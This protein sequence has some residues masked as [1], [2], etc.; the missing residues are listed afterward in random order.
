MSHFSLLF[1]R[2][3]R[4]LAFKDDLWQFVCHLE[5]HGLKMASCCTDKRLSLGEFFFL[6]LANMFHL[7][8]D[9]C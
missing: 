1:F 4:I 7:V 2:L 9:H 8:R 5:G 3:Y 6:Y